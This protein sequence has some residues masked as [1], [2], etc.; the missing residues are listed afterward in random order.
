MLNGVSDE[1]LRQAYI[2]RFTLQRGDRVND[3][4]TAARHFQ[5]LL[6]DEP[7]RERFLV[8]F[9]TGRNTVIGIEELFKGT[10]T[11]AAVYPREVVRKALLVNAAAVV[12]AHNHPSGKLLPSRDDVEITKRIREAVKLIDVCVHDHII[13]GYGQEDYYSFADHGLL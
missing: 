10:L 4:E 3:S 2:R 11:N 7:A 1:V 8:M 5:A 6:V 12:L 13:I 9:L